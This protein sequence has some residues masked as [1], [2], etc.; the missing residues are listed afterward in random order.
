[1]SFRLSPRLWLLAPFAALVFFLWAT[2]QRLERAHAVSLLPAWNSLIGTSDASSLTGYAGGQRALIIPERNEKTFE[3]IAQSQTMVAHRDWRLRAVLY[4]NAPAGRP[5]DSPSLYRWWLAALGAI[6]HAV[7]GKLVGVAI[8]RAALYADPLLLGLALLACSFFCVRHFGPPAAGLLSLGLVTV[9]P[10]AATFLPAVADDRGA[11]ALLALASVLPLLAGVVRGQPVPRWFALAGA[12]GGLGVWFHLATEIPVLI[13]LFAGGLLAAW[14]HRKSDVAAA[15]TKAWRAWSLSGSV[16]ILAA[17]LVEQ[18]PGHLASWRLDAVHPLY[19]VAWL[20]LGELL[21]LACGAFTVAPLQKRSRAW[22]AFFLALA[23]V[24]SVPVMMWRT[25]TAGFLTRDLL[26]TRLA[27]LPNSVSA[28]N[29]A[30]WFNRDGASVTLL[31]VLAPVVI[32]AAAIGL[33]AS[34]HTSVERRA[35]LALALGPTLIALGFACT[36]LRWWAAFDA[37]FLAVLV[38]LATAGGASPRSPWRWL[39]PSLAAVVLLLGVL[40]QWP[41]RE[42]SGTPALTASDA[43]TVIERHLAHWLAE[44]TEAPGAIVYA[45]P[46]VTTTLCFFGGLRGLGTFAPENQLGFGTS[47]TIAAAKTM[48]EAETLLRG[49]NVRYLVIPSWDPFFDNFAALYLAKNFSN[50]GSLLITELRRWN[51]PAWLRPLPYQL[52]V[53]GAFESQSVRVFEVVDEQSP[54]T[55]GARLA[56]YLVETGELADAARIADQL[57]RFPGDLGALSAR[58][59]VQNA[60]G[61]AA[62]AAQT[63]AQLETRLAT[64]ADRFLAWDRRVS[65]ALTLAQADKVEPAIAQARRCVA[66]ISAAK[67]RTL[68]TGSLYNFLMLSRAIAL[69][70]PPEMRAAALKLLPPDLRANF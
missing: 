58:A 4:D 48:E 31:A 2:A 45:P 66:E 47:L 54:A 17:F 22:I 56:E 21:V 29:L 60:R 6:D 1:M 43:Q 63:L 55:A 53:G 19:G 23:A 61:D 39:L 9:F 37:T 34:R 40:V 3:W 7:T 12:L 70:I 57:R 42:P 30:S 32:I 52:P 69:E 14:F 25:D 64:G 20:G 27:S 10:L 15:W 24:A 59:Q 16:T 62:G 35:A 18:F 13:G 44:R 11:A 68:S 26:W 33:M 5:V 51:L 49:R 65:L 28:L 41:H 46:H 50:R 67:L 38:A 36:Q 8:E